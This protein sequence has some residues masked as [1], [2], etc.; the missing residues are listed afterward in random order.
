METKAKRVLKALYW[1]GNPNFGI[2]KGSNLIDSSI[3]AIKGKIKGGS[4]YVLVWAELNYKPNVY[5]TDETGVNCY[6]YEI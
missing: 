1:A 3:D 6:L 2:Y 4:E 5:C